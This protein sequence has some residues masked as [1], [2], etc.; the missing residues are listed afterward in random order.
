MVPFKMSSIILNTKARLYRYIYSSYP[1]GSHN[2]ILLDIF[3]FIL[4]CECCT[5]V[6][7]KKAFNY[8]GS[9][10]PVPTL[11][12]CFV[13]ETGWR[14]ITKMISIHDRMI[15][16]DNACGLIC[17]FSFSFSHNDVAPYIANIT[18]VVDNDIKKSLWHW[19]H[20]HTRLLW[21]HLQPC[22]KAQVKLPI[23]KQ[24]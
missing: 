22:S 5:Y 14:I 3:L 17:C 20:D 16:S 2:L 11:K 7:L 4:R 24:T 23:S 13:V 18:L 6:W 10:H 21:G 9:S 15:Q 12:R 1:T 19:D 8:P